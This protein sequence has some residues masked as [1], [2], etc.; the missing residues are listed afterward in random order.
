MLERMYIQQSSYRG[1]TRIRIMKQAHVNGAWKKQ[2]CQHVGTAHDEL[3]RTVLMARAREIVDTKRHP[4]Q[5]PL[6]FAGNDALGSQVKMVGEYWEGAELVLGTLFDAL[7]ISMRA[8]DL[9]L[10]RNLVIARVMNPVSKRRTASWLAQCL[11]ASY[12]EDD[13][14]RFM[15]RL[16]ARKPQ[17]TKAMLQLIT[18]R[19]PSS[20]QYL[21]YDVTS[22]HWES[23]EEDIDTLEAAGLRKRG[24]SKDH[25]EDLPQ[26]VLGLAVNTLGMPLDCQLY[27]GNTYEGRTL[28][29]GINAV[30]KAV[31]LHQVTVVADAG[32]LTDANLKALEGN[33]TCYIVGA[34]L[35]QLARS[36]QAM[37]LEHDYAAEP[38]W[39]IP[40]GGRRLVLSYSAKRAKRAERGREQSLAR[41]QGLLAR[42]RA[43]RKHP[44][45]EVTIAGQPRLNQEAI[46]QAARWDGIKGYLSNNPALSAEEVIARY[47]ELYRVEQSFRMSKSDLRIR[48]AFHHLRERIQAHVLIC[49]VSLCIMR[50][51]EESIRPLGMTLGDGIRTLEYAKG[52]ILDLKGKSY[53]VPPLYTPSMEGII[54]ALTTAYGIR[55]SI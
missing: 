13:I 9:R 52:A 32:M 25:R 8:S 18:T 45:L 15:D 11:H 49:M 43:I 20:L 4:G 14:Y 12:T 38:I 26:V 21:L 42:N 16:Q 27:S 10:L 2:L 47:A 54:E 40:L 7:C 46:G 1:A 41:L 5:L 31:G 23:E 19:Y 34:R 44:F 3:E 48:P 39:E 36:T 6:T 53:T 55:T 22:V 50:V 33:A 17:V 51:L 29:S 35:R 24:Y 28:V 30:R 37:V